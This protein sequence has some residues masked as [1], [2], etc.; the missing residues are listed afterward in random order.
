MLGKIVSCGLYWKKMR[1]FLA[2]DLLGSIVCNVNYKFYFQVSE[3]LSR[4][5]LFTGFAG[6][7]GYLSPEVLRKEPYGKPVDVWACGKAVSRI[8]QIRGSFPSMILFDFK[9]NLSLTLTG[10]LFAE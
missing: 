3:L 2:I 4:F 1:Q 10:C 8:L 7:P 6:T 5:F 9:V